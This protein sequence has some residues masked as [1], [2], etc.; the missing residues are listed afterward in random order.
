MLIGVGLVQGAWGWTLL[1]ATTLLILLA[2][3]REEAMLARHGGNPPGW[4]ADPD[5]LAWST[6]PVALI[7][8]WSW[9]LVF[10]G[11][12]AAASFVAVQDRLARTSAV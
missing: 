3:G 10:A 12:V 8:G 4:S 1:A 5:S 11:L 6:L 2:L 9:A 7:G